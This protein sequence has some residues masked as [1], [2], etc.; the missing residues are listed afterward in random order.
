MTLKNQDNESAIDKVASAAPQ[1]ARRDV[2]HGGAGLAMAALLGIVASACSSDKPGAD[3][4]AGGMGGGSAA[5]D[6]DVESLNALLTAEYRAIAAYTAGAGL[7]TGAADS[8]PLYALRTVIVD[9]AA[10][11]QSQHKL[12]AA[13]LI[14]AIEGLAGAPV[15]EDEAASGLVIPSALTDNPTIS[16]VLKFAAGAERGAAVAYNQTVG[17]LEDAK[18]RFLASSIEG[19]ES[20]HFITLAALV[21]GLAAPGPEL[22]EETAD[23]VFPAAFVYKVGAEAGLDSMPV[24]YFS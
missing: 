8:D 9:I 11:I 12:H 1:S 5:D 24:D 20:Q 16:N 17:V 23:Q 7:I 10:S 18:F 22:S 13:A 21:L 15:D 6:A 14:D 2:V 3:N 19:D 4:G